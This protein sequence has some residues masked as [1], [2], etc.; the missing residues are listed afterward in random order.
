VGDA[1]TPA[2]TVPAQ[3][4]GNT[5]GAATTRA[6]A[7]G[8]PGIA[9][10]SAGAAARAAEP[11]WLAEVRLRASRRVLWLR[12]LWAQPGY[13]GEQPLAISHSEVDRALTSPAEAADAERAFYRCDER[14]AAIDAQ[15]A[16]LAGQPGDARLDHLV[17]ALG[18]CTAEAAL[19][20]LAAA[21]A[22]DPAISRVFGYL[23]DIG[24]AA[25]PT[26]SLAA[27]LF[28]LGG[29]P[30]P[31]PDSALLRWLLAA[32]VAAGRD[33]F[34][35]TTGWRADTALLPAL[36]G[37]AGQGGSDAAARRA[38]VAAADWSSGASGRVVEPPRGPVLQPEALA[39]IVEFV[40]MIGGGGEAG[41]PIELELVGA[42]GS[43]RT[44][45]AA[46]V[47][48]RL[49]LRLVA[50][51][52]AALA[53]RADAADAA[54]R[55]ARRARL[56]GSVLAWEH[57]EALPAELWRVI[58]AAPLTFLSVR[59]PAGSPGGTAGPRSIRRSVHCGPIARRDRL[60]LWSSLAATQAPAA[61]AEWALRPAEICVAARV[62]PAGN[63]E[64]GEV[65]RRLLM[66]GTPELVSPLPLPYTWDDLVLSPATAAHLRE[67]EAQARDRGLVL[68]DWGFSRLTSPAR[69]TTALFSGP[70]GTGKTMA[71]QVLARSLGLDLYRV[72]LAGV[73][74]KYIGETEKHLRTLFEAC[75]RAPVLL[76]FDE[77][78]ALFG[79]RTQVNDAHD[80][81]ANI[82]IDYVLQRM[83]QFDGLAVLATN[84]KGDLD[85]AL[86]RR[87][88]FIIGFAPP[89]PL[90]RE[91]LWR[92][93]LE[94]ARGVEGGPLVGELDWAR[95]ARELDLTGAGIKSA[96][97][98]AA[99]LARSDGGLIC[100][101]HV[102]AAAR[103]ELEKQGV[104]V[105]PGQMD[106]R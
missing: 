19:F 39:E 16:A 7:S 85:T 29:E 18:L 106:P 86:V 32:P 8:Q 70:S 36:V 71:A 81:Y 101:R 87:L 54:I 33:A 66:A 68:D 90:E 75:E 61:V 10:E 53:A 79:K 93:A 28:G 52:A 13:E 92:L 30:L 3:P 102:L 22:A 74:S 51:D 24:E 26:P 67:L 40:Q 59:E 89:S 2:L 95:L 91:R 69:G 94:D 78:D 34:A 4:D 55:E 100:E 103:R 99:F 82:E 77:A 96:A 38:L 58:P 42:A 47:A 11:R 97:V 84:R 20:M 15:I 72:D 48:A 1:V 64:V 56:D 6:D 105:R 49:G 50:V 80:R 23:L 35:C 37:P 60:R 46:Q 76:L 65:C 41:P 25:D 17:S 14:A 44:A 63:R 88:R 98:A 5:D 9:G 104:V 12:H 57:A 21:A 31:G 83:E 45:L 73:V 27:A 62:A 43:G